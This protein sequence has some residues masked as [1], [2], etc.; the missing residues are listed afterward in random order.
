MIA[1]AFEAVRDDVVPQLTDAQGPIALRLAA[2]FD[3]ERC[4]DAAPRMKDPALLE[5]LSLSLT[6][7]RT[8]AA[9]ESGPKEW[10]TRV[11]RQVIDREL[12]RNTKQTTAGPHQRGTRRLAKDFPGK[13]ATTA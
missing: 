11:V 10:S 7:F 3:R 1:G 8:R 12:L 4:M 9:E 5:R 2:E 6:T 13:V